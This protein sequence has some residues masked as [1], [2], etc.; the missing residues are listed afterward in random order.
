MSE[1]E[2]EALDDCLENFGDAGDQISESLAE[3][4]H[5]RRNTFEIQMSNVETWMSAALTNEDTCLDGFRDLNAT[6]KVT[7][8]VTGHVQYVC[9]LISNALALV[10]RFAATGSYKELIQL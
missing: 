4:K 8:M 1:R 9:E 3:L 7:T 2:K 10:N 6:G 5:L